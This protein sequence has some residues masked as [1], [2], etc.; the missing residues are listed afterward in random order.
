MATTIEREPTTK[1]ASAVKAARVRSLNRLRG[2]VARRAAKVLWRDGYRTC[3]L[4]GE[5]IRPNDRPA[6]YR[7]PVSTPRGDYFVLSDNTHAVIGHV[8]CPVPKAEPYTHPGEPWKC[9]DC[10]AQV[11]AEVNA[12]LWCGYERHVCTECEGAG[13]GDHCPNPVG[14][15]YQPCPGG[16]D[17]G[18]EYPIPA[19]RCLG[20]CGAHINDAAAECCAA[21]EA[22]R[23]GL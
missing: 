20:G 4:C 17:S 13:V 2:N 6:M 3:K 5:E 23:S 14:A 8:S 11:P 15:Q 21:C 16:C 18:F 7:A 1:H 10:D 12:C 19:G 22:G 9:R